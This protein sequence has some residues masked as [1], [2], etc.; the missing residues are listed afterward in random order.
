MGSEVKSTE[1]IICLENVL[2]HFE[3][4]PSTNTQ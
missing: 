3:M 2:E 4:I 1:S